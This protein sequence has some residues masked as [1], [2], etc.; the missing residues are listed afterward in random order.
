M[1]ISIP[2]A[3]TIVATELSLEAAPPALTSILEA[4]ALLTVWIPIVAPIDRYN[5]V[6]H[7]LVLV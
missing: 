6:L 3:R 4:D 7:K 1:D 2:W 5:I